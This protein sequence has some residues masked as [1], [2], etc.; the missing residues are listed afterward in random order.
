ME[1]TLLKEHPVDIYMLLDRSRSHLQE[2]RNGLSADFGRR[3]ARAMST[4]TSNLQ[5]GLGTFVE[6]PE[7]PFGL[8]AYPEL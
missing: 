1:F 4:M 5:L 6:K 3:L 2:R 7:V 8:N